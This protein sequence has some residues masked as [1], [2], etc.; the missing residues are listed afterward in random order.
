MLKKNMH[1]TCQYSEHTVW[2]FKNF[3]ATH[4]LREISFKDSGSAK[5]TILAN[6]EALE[7]DCNDLLQCL[8]AEMY[9]VHIPKIKIQSI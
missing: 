6:L 7:F 2:K 8:M 9:L 4:I 5:T 1:H 3:S